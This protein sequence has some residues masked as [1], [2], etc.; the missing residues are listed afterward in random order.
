MF[1]PTAHQIID[2]TTYANVID[3]EAEYLPSLDLMNSASCSRMDSFAV[4]ESHYKFIHP[5]VVNQE[6]SA[7]GWLCYINEL[8]RTFLIINLEIYYDK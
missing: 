1:C 4:G 2:T 7:R 6:P 8:V 3:I 5:I